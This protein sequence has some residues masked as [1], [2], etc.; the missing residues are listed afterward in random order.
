MK[1]GDMIQTVKD[2][3]G[4]RNTGRIGSRTVD[5]VVLEAINL[6][7]P[8]CVLEAQPDYYNRTATIDLVVG[9]R[10]YPL[11]TLDTDSS[12]IKIK[13]LYGNRCSRADGTSID[14]KQLN[15]AAFVKITQNYEL[16][17]VG[18]PS[19]FALWGKENKLTLD[20]FPSEP[21]LL[22]LYA[23]VYPPIILSGQ[24][25]VPL[26]LDDQWN[27]VVESFAT[28]HCYLKLQQE[29]MYMIWDD[30]YKKQKASI[31]REENQ[32]QSKNIDAG[33][34]TLMVGDPVSDPF[35]NNWNN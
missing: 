34:K 24:D 11:P 16:D 31:S 19:Y 29:R 17:Y 30:L 2:N 25:T 10:V 7:L 1:T 9:T 3:L 18:T 8:H 12:P 23:E 15:Y 35:V 6:A 14:I 27:I 13:D 5:A 22:T 4:N 28:K 33:S 20:Y 32:K 26:P 21:Y